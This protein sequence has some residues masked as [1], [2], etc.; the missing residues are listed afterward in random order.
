MGDTPLG[1]ELPTGNIHHGDTA[2][3]T[4]RDVEDLGIA[5]H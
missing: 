5:A 1:D 4:I 3:A 2:F